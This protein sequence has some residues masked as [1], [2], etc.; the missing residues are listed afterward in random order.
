MSELPNG[1]NAHC[2]WPLQPAR[3]AS[4]CRSR[5]ISRQTSISTAPSEG[6]T[7]MT[8]DGGCAGVIGCREAILATSTPRSP[9]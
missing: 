4:K 2:L 1:F 8:V 7:T 9:H 5:H 6:A 3:Y